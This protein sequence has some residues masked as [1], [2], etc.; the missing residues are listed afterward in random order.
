MV[1]RIRHKGLRRFYEDDDPRGIPSVLRARIHRILTNLDVATRPRD[2][3][4]PG[5]VLHPLKG[6]RD[7]EWSVRVSG[8][9]RITFRFD[10][11]DVTDVDLEDYH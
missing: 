9:W 11:L 2:L 8:N 1:R 4:L 6:D 7:G 10:G 3:D 5:Y